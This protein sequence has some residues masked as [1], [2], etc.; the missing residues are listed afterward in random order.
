V[1]TRGYILNVRV[2]QAPRPLIERGIMLRISGIIVHQTGSASGASSLSSY[3]TQN[4]TGAHF[5]IDKDGA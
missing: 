4:A 2:Q 3:K 1:D 5:L